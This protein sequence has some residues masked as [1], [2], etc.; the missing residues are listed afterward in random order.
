MSLV[1]T[2]RLMILVGLLLQPTTT[3]WALP[4]SR[5]VLLVAMPHVAGPYFARSVVLVTRHGKGSTVGLVLNRPTDVSLARLGGEVGAHRAGDRPLYLGGPVDRHRTVF[6]RR[7]AKPVPESLNLV[8]DI[9]MSENVEALAEA[10]DADLPATELR[11]F[12]GFSAWIPGQ[13]ENEIEREDWIVLPVDPDLIFADPQGL[14]ERL[15]IEYHGGRWAWRR[16][17]AIPVVEG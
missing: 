6:L 1:S 11:V 8:S 12:K 9:Y 10:L 16:P 17:E 4:A 2:L 5:T 14:W 13:L 7:S 15:M 3:F